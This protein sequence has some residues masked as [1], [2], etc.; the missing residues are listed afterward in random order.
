MYK[1]KKFDPTEPPPRWLNCPRK[2][3]QVIVDKFLAF[4]VPLSTNFDRNVPYECRFNMSM[5][6]ESFKR[7]NYNGKLGLVIDLTNTDRFY[8]SNSEVKQHGIKYYKMNCRGHGETPNAE[9]TQL[10]INIVDNFI[11]QHP[12]EIIGVHCTHGFNRT[13]FL[14]CAYLV[15][16]L[17]FSIDMAVA[18]FSQCRQPGIYKQDYINELFRRYAD[19]FNTEVPVAAPLPNWEES[20]QTEIAKSS[21]TS[22][23]DDDTDDDDE[24]IEDDDEPDPFINLLDKKSDQTTENQPPKNEIKRKKGVKRGRNDKTKLNPVFCEPSILGVEPCPDPDEVS[25]VQTLVQMICGW[26]SLSFAGAQPV[27]MDMRN[28]NYLC[29]KKYMV[30]WKADGTRYLM[31]VNGADKVYMLD[32]ENSV[33]TVRNLR[34]PHRKDMDRYL[35][36]TLLDGEFVM[37]I[38]P[39]TNQKIPRFLIYDIIKFENDDVGKMNYQIRLQCIS[40]EIIFAR[41]E[42]FR[43]G[44]LN[45]QIEPFSIRQKLFYKITDTKK[46]LSKDFEKQ[47][48]HGI[49]GLIFQP[50]DEAYRGGRCDTIL[51]WKPSTMNSVDFRLVIRIQEDMG[52]LTEK[53]GELYVTGYD[54]PYSHI[55]INRTL[56]GMHNKIIECRWHEDKWDY[57]RE[58]V[59]K[60]QPNHITTAM[61]VCESIR[62]PVTD[63]YLLDLIQNVEEQRRQQQQYMP[64]PA[65]PNRA[66]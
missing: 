5:L 38:D 53:V 59:D 43:Q 22:N 10:F 65:P 18:L 46:L 42:A 36:N 29:S 15:E 51:K 1:R 12:T 44:K 28:I 37:D 57:M 30:S 40:K 17:D 56:S 11:R 2:A 9:M 23:L 34:F 49:D 41:D 21:H 16:K 32:R 58:R 35:S 45:K 62:N 4:K 39:N 63:Q 55:K 52:M 24:Y 31:M 14:I 8:D 20:E 66:F 61:A 25:R 6:I 54:Q 48:T 7:N 3:S 33:F 50:V 26:K 27:S 47:I 64:P 19:E 60:T 13:G